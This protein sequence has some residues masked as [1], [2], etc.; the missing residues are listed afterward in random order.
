MLERFRKIVS[1]LLPTLIRPQAQRFRKMEGIVSAKGTLRDAS[2]NIVA[3]FDVGHNIVPDVAG[4]LMAR[5]AKDPTEPAG[6]FS[7]IA[8]GTGDPSWDPMNPDPEN[9]LATKLEAEIDRK[10]LAQ[11]YF[12]DPLSGNPT[13]TP[14]NICDFVGTFGPNEGVGAL[15]ELAVFGGDASASADSG[16]LV[17]LIHFPVKNKTAPET[18]TW[19]LRFTF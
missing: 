1:S 10:P 9:P 5:L 17:S 12:V 11:S 15:V 14:T 3:E 13:T 18:L 6:G 2:G 4:I 16:T 8:V 19:A 7:Y